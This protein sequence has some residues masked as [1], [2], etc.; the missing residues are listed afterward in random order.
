MPLPIAAAA[1]MAAR[2]AAAAAPGLLKAGAKKAATAGKQYA[3]ATG[4]FAAGEA[5]GLARN[6]A[7]NASTRA[8]MKAT[9]FLDAQKRRIYETTT[10]AFY[11][12]TRN[13]NRN[14]RPRAVYEN[15]VGTK[16]VNKLTKPGY[17]TKT[18]NNVNKFY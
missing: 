6:I 16:N 7:T 11:T 13:G 15:V 2:T 18:Y 17:L 8:A 14:Y 10:G 9:N 1:L 4:K 12:N 3:V 5:R